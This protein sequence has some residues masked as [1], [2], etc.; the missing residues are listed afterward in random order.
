MDCDRPLGLAL[1]KCLHTFVHKRILLES[2]SSPSF[3]EEEEDDDI[4]LVSAS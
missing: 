4:H 1:K 3:V 2:R